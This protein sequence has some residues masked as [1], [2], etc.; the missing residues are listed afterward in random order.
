MNLVKSYYPSTVADV[1]LCVSGRSSQQSR[2]LISIRHFGYG[3]WDM[4]TV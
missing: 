2:Q 1:L 4:H 3:G